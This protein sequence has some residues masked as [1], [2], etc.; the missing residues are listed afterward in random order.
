MFDLTTFDPIFIYL[1][2]VFSFIATMIFVNLLKG[3]E[4][5]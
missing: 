5:E 3:K 2:M 1:S 4:H